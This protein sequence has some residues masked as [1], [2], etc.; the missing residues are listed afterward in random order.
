MPEL[1]KCFQNF[2]FLN[3]SYSMVKEYHLCVFV[4]WLMLGLQSPQPAF[5]RKG[6]EQLCRWTVLLS[7]SILEKIFSKPALSQRWSKI[8][9]SSQLGVQTVSLISQ[10]PGIAQSSGK[11]RSAANRSLTTLFCT[12]QISQILLNR[13]SS[14]FRKISA[15][16]HF[17]E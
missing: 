14:L 6:A 17:T 11:C 7:L 2:R 10:L 8:S 5:Q 13:R 3:A 15:I 9:V 12:F 16:F 1:S 4:F